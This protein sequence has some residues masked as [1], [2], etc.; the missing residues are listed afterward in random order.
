LALES[1]H[2][3]HWDPGIVNGPSPLPC[4]PLD[5]RHPTTLPPGSIHLHRGSV[6]ARNTE[7]YPTQCRH[8]FVVLRR[9]CTR[10]DDNL[11]RGTS[12]RLPNS[13]GRTPISRP[14]H[15]LLRR[16]EQQTVGWSVGIQCH[17]SGGGHP[18]LR[19]RSGGEWGALYDL[20]KRRSG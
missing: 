14:S 15:R 9:C 7:M 10:F 17:R 4:K 5:L 2:S 3:P 20:H 6:L 8:R 1:A 12:S 16:G 19:Q 11:L 13:V 18:A